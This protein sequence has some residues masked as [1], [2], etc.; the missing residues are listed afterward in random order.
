MT[1]RA[2]LLAVAVLGL[3]LPG[4]RAESTFVCGDP[5]KGMSDAVCADRELIGLGKAVDARFNTLVA[6]ADALTRL[7]LRRDQGWFAEILGGADTPSFAGREDPERLRLKAVLARRL[8]TLDAI[9][10]RVIAAT[11]AGIW[12]N[13]LATITVSEAAEAGTLRVTLKAKLAHEGRGET[14]T[15]DLAGTLTA[16][17]SGWF[18]G[19]LMNQDG[20]QARTRLRLQ[21]NSLRV[22]QQ[23]DDGEPRA[24][25]PL[26]IVTGSYFASSPAAT[27]TAAAAVARTIAPS[28]KCA[29]AQNSDEEEIC[30]DPELAA[31]DAEIARLYAETLRGL[32]PRLAAQ[33]RADQ[34]GWAKDN[35]TA[36]DNALHSPAAK[37]DDMLHDTDAARAELLRRLDERRAMLVNLD[38]KRVG[39]LGLWEA[40]N[41]V[42]TIGPARDKTDGTVTADGFKW[43]VGERKEFCLPH[44]AGHM[45]G[46]TFKPAEEFPT[47]TRDGGTLVLSQEA[48]D[49]DDMPAGGPAPYCTNMRSAKARLFPVKA[50]AGEGAKFDR[51]R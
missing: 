4:A 13:A 27:G 5:H 23:Y 38:L 39:M 7:L 49:H 50:A 3:A 11:P 44:S 31:R 17:G 15:C 12:A 28:F 46:D 9:K 2:L 34:R 20:A 21:G 8:A 24:C 40:Y 35:P 1:I 30:A 43:Q 33:L 22:V 32:A 48:P 18:A 36:F 51:Q 47:L 25:A 19:A 26:A 42:L 10:P 45:E 14:L 41:A 6:Q 16:G 29:A 37:Q